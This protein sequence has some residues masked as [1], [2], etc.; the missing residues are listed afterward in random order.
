MGVFD[1]GEENGIVGLGK[2]KNG[3]ELKRPLLSWR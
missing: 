1:F 3:V 2:K